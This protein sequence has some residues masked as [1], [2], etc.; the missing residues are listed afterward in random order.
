MLLYYFTTPLFHH[1]NLQFNP[2][3]VGRRNMSTINALYM[4]PYVHNKNRASARS[5]CHA[6]EQIMA[7]KSP[8]DTHPE[9]IETTGA[10][11]RARASTR[12]DSNPQ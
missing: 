6:R 5:L 10:L 9:P 3:V 12:R 2:P 7:K 4:L 1:F 8:C 11:A